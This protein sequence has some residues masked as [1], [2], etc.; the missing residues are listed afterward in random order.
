[1]RSQQKNRADWLR[2]KNERRIERLLALTPNG[3]PQAVWTHAVRLR[4]VPDTPGKAVQAY[5]QAHPLRAD[6]L[7][8]ALATRSGTPAGWVWRVD[9]DGAD[10]MADSFRIPPLPY[11]EQ[12]FA[13]GA[14]SCCVCGQPVFRYGW[15]TNDWAERAPNGRASWH[16]ACVAAWKFWNAPSE[17]DRLLKRV[18]RHRCAATR[19]RLLRDAEVDHRIPLFRVWREQ[20]H[21]PWPEL[22]A[23]WGLPNLQVLNREAHVRKCA[24]E[25]RER[26]QARTVTPAE[27]AA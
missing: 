5:W 6:R 22:L 9:R 1:M 21:R 18:Q 23:H 27:D 14:G 11:R 7:A 17:Q 15:H 2:L 16:A 4:L 12:A 20:R 10:G 26:A 8:R 19:R 13:R 25:A 3:F 24:E